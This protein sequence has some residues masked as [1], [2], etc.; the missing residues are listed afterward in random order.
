[1]DRRTALQAGLMLVC[2]STAGCLGSMFET[3]SV[4]APPP[5][6]E[7]RPK[8]V[9]VPTHREGMQRID[10]ISN[11][12]LTLTVFYSYPHRF[13]TVT[14]TY[15]KKIPYDESETIHLMTTLT[16]GDQTVG[17]PASNLQITISNDSETVVTKRLWSMLSQ[18]M[19]VHF[20]DNVTLAGAGTYTLDVTMDPIT[21]RLAGGLSDLDPSSR[22]FS[23]T[24]EYDPN[25]R[26]DISFRTLSERAGD[27]DALTPMG[28]AQN[29]Q[30]PTPE[31]LAGSTMATL[32]SGDARLVVQRLES[33]PNGT[34]GDDPY[35]AVSARTPYNRYPLVSMRLSATVVT[36]EGDRTETNLAPTITPALGY[37]YGAPVGA[38]SGADEITLQI[39]QPPQIARHEG[40]ETAFLKMENPTVTL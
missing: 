9:Y 37:H 26:D 10:T 33:P 22:T 39:K 19:G 29:E 25:E 16:D 28:A 31:S 24:F 15:T 8:A 36:G 1:M 34:D 5:L 13:W 20:G 11:G 7:D 2:S 18:N 6:L 23:T 35:L 27:R 40:Y 38:L 14:D 32:T 21:V 4:Y 3:R 30:L 12:G 17:L